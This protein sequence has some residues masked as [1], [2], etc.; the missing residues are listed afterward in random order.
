MENQTI[1]LI[2][3]SGIP[4]DEKQ[5][6]RRGASKLANFLGVSIQES[7]REVQEGSANLIS[8]IQR[9][10]NP[11][12]DQVLIKSFN[13]LRSSRGSG[14]YNIYILKDDI[15]VPGLNYIFGIGSADSRGAIISSYQLQNLNDFYRTECLETLVDHEGAHVFGTDEC[16]NGL[17]VG[18]QPKDLQQLK[19]IITPK[20]FLAEDEHLLPWCEDCQRTMKGYIDQN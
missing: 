15:S 6:V 20:R 19:E 18:N 4:E 16:Y 14:S 12:T 2:Y 1:N 17:C 7:G 8:Y 13:G 11:L 9:N 10:K 5:A 3:Q